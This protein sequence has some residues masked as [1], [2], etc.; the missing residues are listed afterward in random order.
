VVQVEKKNYEVVLD[1]L[2]GRDGKAVG[3]SRE[4]CELC[5]IREVGQQMDKQVIALRD[6]AQAAAAAAPAQFTFESRPAGVDVAVDGKAEGVTPLSLELAAGTHRLAFTAEGYHGSERTVHVE[7]GTN[8]FVT[9]DLVP[10]EQAAP[11]L[12]PVRRPWRLMGLA[13][14]VAGT[15]AVAAGAVALSFDGDRSSASSTIR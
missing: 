12:S 6:Y 3:Q 14:L 10:E 1:L 2:G 13:A 9:V 11:L 15:L 7:S 4:R 5:G 8:G